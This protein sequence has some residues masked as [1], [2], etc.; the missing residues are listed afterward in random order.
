[1]DLF[2]SELIDPENQDAKALYKAPE[3]ISR[4]LLS[5]Q[6]DVWALGVSLFWLTCGHLP[7]ATLRETAESPVPWHFYERSHHPVSANFKNLINQ[8]LAKD[9]DQRPSIEQV[10]DHSWFKRSDDIK[11]VR[12]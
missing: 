7:F 1:M 8:M 11:V 3:V 12:N 5:K 6:S 2:S 10:L 9:K 4:G